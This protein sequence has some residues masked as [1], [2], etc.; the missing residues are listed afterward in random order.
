[1]P[2]N[3]PLSSPCLPHACRKHKKR[4]E[5]SSMRNPKQLQPLLPYTSP[6]YSYTM[7][8]DAHLTAG[9]QATGGR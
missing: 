6:H 2:I 8:S 9:T 4:R 1:M 7:Y 3:R 5:R